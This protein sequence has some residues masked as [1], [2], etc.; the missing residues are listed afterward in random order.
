MESMWKSI[1]S[2]CYT[3]WNEKSNHSYMSLDT[4]PNGSELKDLDTAVALTLEI[5]QVGPRWTCVSLKVL[6]SSIVQKWT[7]A[8]FATWNSGSAPGIRMRWDRVRKTICRSRAEVTCGQVECSTMA[9]A[10]KI[11]HFL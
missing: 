2:N 6:I 7:V 11:R 9:V 3:G 1:I 10:D 8:L 4:Y 5:V